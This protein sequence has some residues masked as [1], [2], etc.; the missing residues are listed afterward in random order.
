MNG[1]KEIKATDVEN[2]VKLIGSDWMLITASDGERTNCMT[3]SWGSLGVLWNKNVC[4]CFIRPQRHTFGIAEKTDRLSFS[5]FGEEYR[6][7]LS[8]CGSRSGRDT[9]KF[10]ETGLDVSFVDG[11]PIINQAK[12]VL[13]CRKLYSDFIK[14]ENFIDNKLLSNYKNDDFHKFYVCEIEKVLLKT[15]RGI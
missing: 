9:D 12:L 13:V 3:A 15:E 10:A 8:F 1:F 11:T 6:K 4:T 14:K 7:A 5:F 2:A